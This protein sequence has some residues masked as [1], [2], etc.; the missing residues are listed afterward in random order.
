MHTP[1]TITSLTP[2]E[3][4]SFLRVLSVLRTA[5]AEND[6]IITIPAKSAIANYKMGI[7][8]TNM[9]HIL[10]AYTINGYDINDVIS[11]YELYYSLEQER[12]VD[13]HEWRD[14][15]NIDINK[16]P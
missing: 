1:A 14:L 13:S 15:F 11:F 6:L 2:A 12:V 9:V 7:F 10:D 3:I 5:S 4:L 8:D 16:I